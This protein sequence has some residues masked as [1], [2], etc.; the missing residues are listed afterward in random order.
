MERIQE[1]MLLDVPPN[2][3]S[4][5]QTYPINKKPSAFHLIHLGRLFGSPS[6]SEAAAPPLPW[7]PND[8]RSPRGWKP[9]R[10]QVLHPLGSPPPPSCSVIFSLQQNLLRCSANLACLPTRSP[11]AR[12]MDRRKASWAKKRW[13]LREKL[14]EGWGLLGF[15]ERTVE[16]SLPLREKLGFFKREKEKGEES[17]VKEAAKDLCL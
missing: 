15:L 8:V 7:N 6:S 17:R 11:I 16:L 2:L 3:A 5:P 10:R 13:F 12:S 14:G 9:R 1:P 4:E